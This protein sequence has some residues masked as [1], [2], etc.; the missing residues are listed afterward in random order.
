MDSKRKSRYVLVGLF[1][2]LC[3]CGVQDKAIALP[4]IGSGDVTLQAE[5]S[6]FSVNAEGEA[7]SEV[8][9]TAEGTD[10]KQIYVHVCGA[11]IN[12]GV[13]ILPIGSRREDAVLAAGGFS[14]NACETYVNL[15]ALLADGE[16]LY[17]PD[18]EEGESLKQ[19][20]LQERDMLVNINTAGEE[21]LCTLPGIGSARA[22]DIIAYRKQ[23]GNFLCKEDIMQV[24]GIKES[25][26][27]KIC[28][29]IVVE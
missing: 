23:H 12:P 16:Q 5:T 14:E 26:Y 10:K 3:G 21:E 20:A 25:I 27:N 6:A 11:V 24:S 9:G 15:A 7:N 28:E 18:R 13:V 29:S 2:L 4:I 8:Y 17:I 22:K 1:W 19:A